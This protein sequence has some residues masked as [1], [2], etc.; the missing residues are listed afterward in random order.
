MTCIY[1]ADPI[2]EV[3]NHPNLESCRLLSAGRKV[4][5]A[6]RNVD[7]LF[8]GRNRG[9]PACV[10]IKSSRSSHLCYSMIAE[11]AKA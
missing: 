6:M 7:A 1:C 10:S 8:I 5:E 2:A 4:V 11:V 9:D 3:I